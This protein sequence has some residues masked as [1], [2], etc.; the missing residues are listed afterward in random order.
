MGKEQVA[1]KPNEVTQLFCTDA[2]MLAM[3]QAQNTQLKHDVDRYKAE[4]EKEKKAREDSEKMRVQSNV[5]LQAKLLA[6]QDRVAELQ[7][8]LLALRSIVNAPVA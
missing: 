4:A 5:S 2:Q 1:E 7:D 8:R 6:S 3:L